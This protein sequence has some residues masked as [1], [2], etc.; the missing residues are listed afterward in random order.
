MFIVYSIWGGGAWSVVKYYRLTLKD[1]KD[2]KKSCG[3][4]IVVAIQV[5]KK[6]KMQAIYSA[7]SLKGRSAPKHFSFIEHARHFIFGVKDTWVE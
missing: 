7:L 4:H 6:K 1:S 2:S 3:K 5:K